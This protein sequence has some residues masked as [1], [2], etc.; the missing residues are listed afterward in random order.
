MIL[1][2]LRWR[3]LTKMPLRADVASCFLNVVV[4]VSSCRRVPPKAAA[5]RRR[6]EHD[7]SV[8]AAVVAKRL[9]RGPGSSPP[10]TPTLV[11]K[12][13]TRRQP[14]VIRLAMGLFTDLRHAVSPLAAVPWI[15]LDRDP[16]LRARDRRQQRHLQRG[17]H[18]VAAAA[19][20]RGARRSRR[21]LADRR[22]RAG[23]DRADLPASARM[24]R[25]RQRRSRV[26]RS[27][28]RTTGARSSRDAASRRASGST[29]CRPASSTRWASARCS[30]AA[31]VLKTTCP[32]R[33]RSRS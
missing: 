21:G 32:T 6:R 11:A 10:R 19:A 24:D 12:R 16:D 2:K 25:G 33:P 7:G 13:W 20:G 14:D 4:V 30:A 18:R 29:A 23:G 9:T 8:T 31:S 27:W 5:R 28:D 17:Q 15:C 1:A 22:G 26:R 3:A